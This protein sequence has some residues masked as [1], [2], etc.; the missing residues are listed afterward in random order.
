MTKE[1][2]IKAL[3]DEL[4]EFKTNLPEYATPEDVDLKLKELQDTI[5]E[6][7]TDDLKKSIED[8][9]GAIEQQ[10]IEM[11][12]LQEG[13]EQEKEL[14]QMIEGKEE[15]SVAVVKARSGPNRLAIK[16]DVNC[17]S[18]TNHTLAK[19]FPDVGHIA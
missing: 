2:I 6:L 5:D 11:K 18:V 7:G 17:A 19:R 3:Q 10:G 1:E 14:G 4:V 9:T 15:D 8:L 12:K 16:T 13:P